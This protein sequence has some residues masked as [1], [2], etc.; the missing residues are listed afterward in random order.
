[1]TPSPHP[2]AQAP[3]DQLWQAAQSGDH[4]AFAHIVERY[5]SLVCSVAYAGVGNL[6][7]SEDLA[8][9]TFVTAWRQLGDL[10]EPGKLRAWLCGITRTLAANTRR[11]DGRRGG[12]PASLDAVAE[13]VA[14]EDDA[15]AQVVSREQEA[16]LWRTIS[17]L[18]ES[19]REPL[20]LFYREGQSIATVASQLELTEDA[21]KQRLSRG[22]A[23]VRDDMASFVESTL[24]RSRPTRAFTAGVLAARSPIRLRAAL[25]CHRAADGS[26]VAG[27]CSLHRRNSS[28]LRR[29]SRFDACDALGS[30][31]LSG[32]AC[33]APRGRYLRVHD[34]EA[35]G[36]R[37]IPR[38]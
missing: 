1:M 3:D 35:P 16:L 15:L 12:A 33:L 30:P 5:Q 11:R 37:F 28:M 32:L 2:G 21:V 7:A 10:R 9:D 14:A 8:Q 20:V 13:P 36:V 34:V 22:R 17:T 23:L 6:A 31:A 25:S 27:W 18:P 29:R 24:T 26:R 4:D 19:Y 38:D